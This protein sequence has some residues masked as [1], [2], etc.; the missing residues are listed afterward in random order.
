MQIVIHQDIRAPRALVFATAID[1]KS[2]PN[3]ISSIE[4]TEFLTR[5]PIVAGTRIRQARRFR[6]RALTETMTFTEFEPPQ[7]F[8]LTGSN[9]G[10]AYVIA[11][12]FDETREGTRM[13]LAFTAAPRGMGARLLSPLA[14]LFRADLAR[15]IKNDLAEL[16]HAVEDRMG[17]PVAVA[18][19]RSAG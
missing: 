6:R 15:Q 5:E 7:S 9:H 11:H 12:I 17:K 14:L 4:R 2:W 18:A 16:A 13:T 3:I 1:V 10:A 8:V 19:R